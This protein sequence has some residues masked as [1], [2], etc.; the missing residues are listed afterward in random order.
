MAE[1]PFSKRSISLGSQKHHYRSVKSIKHQNEEPKQNYFSTFAALLSNTAGVTVMLMPKLFYQAGVVSGVMQIIGIAFLAYM[2]ASQLCLAGRVTKTRT[3]YEIIYLA[4]GRFHTI[5]NISYF[6]LLV[7]NII[8]YHTFV[9]KNLAPLLVYLFNLGYKHG[10]RQYIWFSIGIA[11]IVHLMILPF[12]FSRKLRIVKQLTTICSAA[13]MLGV[14]VIIAVYCAPSYFGMT[15]KIVDWDLIELF[16]FDGLYVSI[17]YYLLSF[18]FHLSVMD[19]AA[20]LYPPTTKVT[21]LILIG[22]CTVAAIIYLVVSFA[23]Y[24]TIFTEDNLGSMTNY[25]TFLIINLGKN[26]VFL[27]VANFLV[28]FSVIFAN[29]LNYVPMIKYLNHEFNQKPISLSKRAIDYMSGDSLA[30]FDFP[31]DEDRLAY[32]KRNRIIVWISFTLVYLLHVVTVAASVRLD[33]IFDFVGALCGPP[34]LLVMPG[35]FTLF[36]LRNDKVEGANFMDYFWG[37][38]LI[39]T[40]AAIWVFCVYGFFKI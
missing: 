3:F 32:K 10:T 17:G 15:E 11:T 21:N 7:G 26:S 16:K 1:N 5:P 40:G 14:L 8:C 36:I 18:C 13:I 6:I 37:Y 39:V 29:I 24:L 27:Y 4:F 12:L 22:N 35:L 33:V 28:I 23:G 31:A 34:V 19:I 20:E 30:D 25:V 38:F 2:A 9:L